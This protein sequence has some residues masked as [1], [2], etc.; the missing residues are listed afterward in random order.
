M[1]ERPTSPRSSDPLDTSLRSLAADVD[2]VHFVDPRS[3]RRRGDRRSVQTAVAGGLAGVLLVGVAGGVAWR[4]TSNQQRPDRS[5]TIATAGPTPTEAPT[6]APPRVLTPAELAAAALVPATAVAPDATAR[7][8]YPAK[9]LVPCV[10]QGDGVDAT[11]WQEVTA[12]GGPKLQQRV[13][14]WSTTAGAGNVLADYNDWAL[15]CPAASTPGGVQS[16]P[17]PVRSGVLAH[18]QQAWAVVFQL[19][20]GSNATTVV[21]GAIQQDRAVSE[22]WY[23]DPSAPAGTQSAVQSG[24]EAALKA[25]SARLAEA[26]A[27]GG[28]AQASSTAPASELT[29]PYQPFSGG[30]EAAAARSTLKGIDVAGASACPWIGDHVL[31]VFSTDAYVDAAGPALVSKGQRIGVGDAFESAPMVTLPGGFD[32]GGRHWDQAVHVPSAPTA[33][34]A[35]ASVPAAT[36]PA[37]TNGGRALDR[38]ALLTAADLPRP[39]GSNVGAWKAVDT[40]AGAGM[41]QQDICGFQLRGVGQPAVVRGY[42]TGPAPEQAG[43]H[44]VWRL[45]DADAARAAYV[46]AVSQV[47]SCPTTAA[48][49]PAGDP[50]VSVDS[51]KPVTV[52]DQAYLVQVSMDSAVT[53]QAKRTQAIG[54][55]LSGRTLSLVVVQVDAQDLMPASAWTPGLQAAASAVEAYA[56]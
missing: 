22:I 30:V 18:G 53:T 44:A 54:L 34:G 31:L 38:G 43:E 29:V 19:G 42:F 2:R 49:D 56:R 20:S 32:C 41:F 15:R 46:Q 7:H 25:A 39:T 50:H 6:T 8:D 35:G 23:A 27:G 10:N 9:L 4:A 11:A 40:S 51:A 21:A 17:L 12:K 36:A 1:S 24:F 52:G 14:V 26:V 28:E 48:A 37:G 3:V 5:Q 55:V 45:A 47:R 16:S 33:T 13:T